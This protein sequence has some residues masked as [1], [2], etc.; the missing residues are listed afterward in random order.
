MVDQRGS[1]ST[2][3]QSEVAQTSSH[4]ID[5][6]PRPVHGRALSLRLT[7]SLTELLHFSDHDQTPPPCG[8]DALLLEWLGGCSTNLG[9]FGDFVYGW[10]L[11]IAK[12]VPKAQSAPNVSAGGGRPAAVARGG[13][14]AVPGRRTAA[15]RG[16]AAE[17]RCGCRPGGGRR[18]RV[19]RPRGRPA[20]R[21]A[22]GIANQTPTATGESGPPRARRRPRPGG[23]PH[24]GVRPGRRSRS[25]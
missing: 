19:T 2:N 4:S 6:A 3:A 16:S 13:R 18:E 7:Q 15:R 12:S 10:R 11:K 21:R 23:D 20:G 22:G 1:I 5:T 14:P 8:A 9:A 17:G 25:G 24:D